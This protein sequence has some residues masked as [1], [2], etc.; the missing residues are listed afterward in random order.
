MAAEAAEAKGAVAERSGVKT[1]PHFECCAVSLEDATLGE[2]AGAAAC[3]WEPG[4]AL[5]HGGSTAAGVCFSDVL[6]WDTG[7]W[8]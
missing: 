1:P 2:R 4:K 8:Q 3:A 7:T 6:I 5:V